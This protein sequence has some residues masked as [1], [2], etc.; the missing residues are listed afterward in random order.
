MRPQVARFLCAGK[1]MFGNLWLLPG[2]L[3]AVLR[4]PTIEPKPKVPA[5]ACC[6]VP[7]IGAQTGSTT[8]GQSGLGYNDLCLW[9]SHAAAC[10]F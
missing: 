8:R 3:D 6:L 5:L 7:L 9:A 10:Y 4:S 1:M 2:G